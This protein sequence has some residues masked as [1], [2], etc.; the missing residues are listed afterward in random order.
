MF[1][2]CK[3]E[4]PEPKGNH[5]WKIQTPSAKSQWPPIPL[6]QWR[7]EKTSLTLTS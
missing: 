7:R 5:G 1:E 6:I 3:I 4:Q 2:K